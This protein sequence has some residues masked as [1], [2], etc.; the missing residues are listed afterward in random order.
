MYGNATYRPQPGN[1]IEFVRV[2]SRI[3][4]EDLETID[5]R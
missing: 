1:S 5:P 2:R 3:P 4:N